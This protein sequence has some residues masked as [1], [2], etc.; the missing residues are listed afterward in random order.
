MR[1]NN[2]QTALELLE[3]SRQHT[4]TAQPSAFRSVLFRSLSQCCEQTGD[5]EKSRIYAATAASQ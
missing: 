2:W 3:R 5:L 1:E 4:T